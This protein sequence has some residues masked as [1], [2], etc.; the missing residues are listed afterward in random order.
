MFAHQQFQIVA[1]PLPNNM[2]WL[3]QIFESEGTMDQIFESEETIMLLVD[4]DG[5]SSIT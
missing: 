1:K 4:D 5:E 2:Q 3:H